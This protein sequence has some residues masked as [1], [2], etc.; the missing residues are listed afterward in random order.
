MITVD[1]TEFREVQSSLNKLHRAVLPNAVRFTLNDLAF[2]VKKNTL[3]ESIQKN[4]E[5]VKSPSLFKKHSLVMKAEGWDVSKMKSTVGLMPSSNTAKVMDRI[6][7]HEEGGMLESRFIANDIARVGGLHKGKILKNK[8]LGSIKNIQNVPF[9]NKQELIK[10]V[11][12]TGIKRGGKGKGNAVLYGHILYEIKGFKRL[13]KTNTI[14]LHLDRIYSYKK[15]RHV[16]V[17]A[18]HFMAEAV[19][20]TAVNI[21][22]AFTKNVNIQIAKFANI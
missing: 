17:K 16:K 6:A 21:Q 15:N 14:E 1:F 9:G 19:S 3:F 11:T 10:A 5:I 7:T 8:W 18:T 22:E 13:R 20:K 12:R 4:F 2:D